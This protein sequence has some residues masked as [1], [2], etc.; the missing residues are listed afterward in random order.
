MCKIRK[1]RKRKEGKRERKS[2]GTVPAYSFE[3]LSNIAR[4]FSDF[5][6]IWIFRKRSILTRLIHRH[7]ANGLNRKDVKG[8][9]DGE[10]RR[11]ETFS[12]HSCAHV[13]HES[14]CDKDE[15]SPK[16]DVSLYD[17]LA[18]LKI[19]LRTK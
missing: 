4:L 9:R 7:G 12:I 19:F 13:N 2:T 17:M 16:G 3:Y 6:A 8:R 10:F 1:K 5:R 11:K 14:T 15:Y 18:R